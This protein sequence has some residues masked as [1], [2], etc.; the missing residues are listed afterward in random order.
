MAR[1]KG[2]SMK[3]IHGFAVGEVQGVGYRY[4]AVRQ[5]R[6]LGLVGWVKN[7]EDGSVEFWAEGQEEDLKA[8]VQWAWEGPSSA[9]VD[10]VRV[11]WVMASGRY[12]SFGVAFS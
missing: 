11:E 8:F 5:A 4:S 1:K 10:D 12:A 6:G 9:R 7:E 2:G 3:A